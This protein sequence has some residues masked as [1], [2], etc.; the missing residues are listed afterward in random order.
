MIVGKNRL[1]EHGGKTYHLQAEDLG[2]EHAS[3]EVRVYDQGSVL[4]RKRMPYDEVLA[5]KLPRIEQEEEVRSLM[6]KALQT[7]QAAI[8]KGKLT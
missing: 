4:W 2:T 1:F 3:F 7:V 5:K 8:A 6:E